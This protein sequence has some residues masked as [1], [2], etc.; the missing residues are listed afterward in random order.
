MYS[1]QKKFTSDKAVVSR[2]FTLIELLVVIAII[3][4][5]AAMLMPAFN[6]ARMAA[7]KTSCKNNQ[8]QIGKNL[9]MYSMSYNDYLMSIHMEDDSSP[10]GW[11]IWINYI[12]HHKLWGAPLSQTGTARYPTT[13]FEYQKI[14]RCPANGGTPVASFSPNNSKGTA[15]ALIDYG[16]NGFIGRYYSSGT[17]ITKRDTYFMLSKASSGRSKPSQTLYLM[18]QWRSA[19]MAGKD[20]ITGVTYYTT[21]SM[22]MDIGHK[23]AHPGGANQLFLDG[24]AETLNGFHALI[25]GTSPSIAIWNEGAS[26]TYGFVSGK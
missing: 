6:Q 25:S 18:D 3:A 19:I 5:L 20:Q 1:T 13:V 8:N 15:A 7:T 14:T 4:I 22:N 2:S 10:Q 24:H 21:S 23:S 9:T 17:W 26:Y 12:N 16:Y 11:R